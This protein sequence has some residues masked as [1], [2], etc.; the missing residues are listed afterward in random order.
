MEKDCIIQ[1]KVVNDSLIFVS[2]DGYDLR[3]SPGDPITV[4]KRNLWT[5]DTLGFL[6]EEITEREKHRMK[7]MRLY[8]VAFSVVT[9]LI[10]Y[11][12]VCD[13]GLHTFDEDEQYSF[14]SRKLPSVYI[15]IPEVDID[16]LPK[17]INEYY[18]QHK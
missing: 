10:W 15:G 9:R 18:R 12:S 4:T 16:G 11:Q 13:L 1:C 6:R 14:A 8:T 3:M 17:D 2:C 5:Q 7:G